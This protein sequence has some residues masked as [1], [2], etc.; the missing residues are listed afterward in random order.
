MVKAEIIWNSPT[1]QLIQSFHSDFSCSVGGDDI[2]FEV[3]TG[4]RQG[5]VM[6]ALIFNLVIDWLMGRTTEAGTKGIRW[7]P[8]FTLNDLDFA[9]DLALIFDIHRHM[10][11]KDKPEEN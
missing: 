11:D 5:C 8:F 9:D 7:T 10:Q 1:V 3:K 4:I 6:S 2:W